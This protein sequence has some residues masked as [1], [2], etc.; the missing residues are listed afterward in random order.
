MEIQF[1]IFNFL[2]LNLDNI[3]MLIF[4]FLNNIWNYM[5]KRNFFCREKQKMKLP[6]L[7]SKSQTEI[8]G[9]PFETQLYRQQ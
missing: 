1:S 6:E 7:D 4:C 8:L 3:P 5:E 2:N 9:S